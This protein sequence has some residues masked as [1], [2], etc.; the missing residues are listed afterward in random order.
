[1]AAFVASLVQN[2]RDASVEADPE[3]DR[4]FSEG[5]MVAGRLRIVRFIDRGAMGEVYEAFDMRLHQRIALKTIRREL[6]GTGETLSRFEREI[7]MAREVAHPNL[8]RV[9]DFLEDS[10]GIPCYTMELIQGESLAALLARERPLPIETALALI[11]QI[12]NG[13]DALHQKEMIHGC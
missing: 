12:A 8:C 3:R 13:V 5:A 4:T 11:R 2:D 10:T 7:R 6:V 1:M 9:F